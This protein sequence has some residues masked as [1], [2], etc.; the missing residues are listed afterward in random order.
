MHKNSPAVLLG[1]LH[2][3]NPGP[4]HPLCCSPPP[5][6][7]P[8]PRCT[9]LVSCLPP[10]TL[11]SVSHGEEGS[12]SAYIAQNCKQ[13]P[14][15]ETIKQCS[16]EVKITGG[17]KKLQTWKGFFLARSF[18]MKFRFEVKRGQAAAAG[19]HGQGCADRSESSLMP[20]P[21]QSDPQLLGHTL[22]PQTFPLLVLPGPSAHHPPAPSPR[23]SPKRC[24]GLVLAAE[25]AGLAGG[26]G[27]PAWVP[28]PR[29]AGRAPSGTRRCE[30]APL[31]C[32]QQRLFLGSFAWTRLLSPRRL[33]ILLMSG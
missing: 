17:K 19:Q 4:F 20:V 31:C 9:T 1:K 13:T 25:P 15:Q 5:S 28:V 22:A 14:F 12:N 16:F 27:L 11:Q 7:H 18:F 8:H 10:D 29:D 24:P 32:T 30:T 23:C 21:S 33:Q 2:I 3:E 6:P 26:P